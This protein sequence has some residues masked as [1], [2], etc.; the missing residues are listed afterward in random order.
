MRKHIAWYVKGLKD[1][2]NLRTVVNKIEEKEK[3]EQTLK[4]YFSII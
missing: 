4:E 3:L 1:A 2:S